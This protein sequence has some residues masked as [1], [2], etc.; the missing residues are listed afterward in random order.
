MSESHDTEP[1]ESGPSALDELLGLV[2]SLSDVADEIRK[3]DPSGRPSEIW[4]RWRLDDGLVTIVSC[5]LAKLEEPL[6]EGEHE[7]RYR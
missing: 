1:P 2:D 4:V 5:T 3:P 7:G 6:P